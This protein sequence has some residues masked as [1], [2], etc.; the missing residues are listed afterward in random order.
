VLAVSNY[1][2]HG[3]ERNERFHCVAGCG[4][5]P[6]SDLYQHSN[7]FANFPDARK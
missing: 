5:E 1:E 6:G 2:R 7:I 3:S 4:S